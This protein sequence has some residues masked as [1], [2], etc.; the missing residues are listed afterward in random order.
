MRAELQN[1]IGD[2]KLKLWH[3]DIKYVMNIYILKWIPFL[4]LFSLLVIGP[5]LQGGPP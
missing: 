4:I 5:W 1:K 2:N 3:S